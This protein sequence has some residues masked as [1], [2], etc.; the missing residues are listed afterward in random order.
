MQR[1]ANA[2]VISSCL[3]HIFCCGLP[4]LMSITSLTALLGVSGGDLFGMSWMTHTHDHSLMIVSGVILFITGAI[5]WIGSRIDCRTDGQCV[6]EPCDTKKDYS[7]II[8]YV[9]CALYGV[10]L[11]VY[12]FAHA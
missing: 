11:T 5:Q 9:A 10:N 7:R 8:F 1:I 4:L 3:V 2:F 6:H 12:L